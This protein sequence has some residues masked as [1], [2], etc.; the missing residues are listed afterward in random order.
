MK[1]VESLPWKYEVAIPPDAVSLKLIY[2][3]ANPS[4]LWSWK[5]FFY[6]LI[7]GFNHQI[8][9]YKRFFNVREGSDLVAKIKKWK[10][11]FQRQKNVRITRVP[12]WDEVDMYNCTSVNYYCP[13]NKCYLYGCRVNWPLSTRLPV[14]QVY[15][16]DSPV[17]SLIH[18]TA[19]YNKPY[20]PGRRVSSLDLESMHVH[21]NYSFIM[22]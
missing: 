10:K 6:F 5:T 19:V 3:A 7:W 4:L 9:K 16:P 21:L 11:A 17:K 20:S 15:L 22:T 1:M 2:P 12:G 13:V 8:R 18:P 14:E